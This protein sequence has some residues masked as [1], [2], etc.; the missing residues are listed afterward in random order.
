MPLGGGS[1]AGAEVETV[2]ETELRGDAD[3]V[4]AEWDEDSVWLGLKGGLDEI[5][6]GVAVAA[7]V[8]AAAVVFAV[9]ILAD[10]EAGAGRWKGSGTGEVGGAGG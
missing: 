8:A 6:V 1:E 3:V 10:V 2:I 5:D 4:G 9:V 7:A